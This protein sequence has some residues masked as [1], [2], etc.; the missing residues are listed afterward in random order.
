MEKFILDKEINVFCIRAKSFPNG[1]L[2]AHQQLHALLDSTEDRNFFGISYPGRQGDI[3]YKAAVEESFEGEGKKL[4]CEAFTIKKGEYVSETLMD[5]RKDETV[6]ARTF[7]KLLAAPAIDK[8]TGY[9]LEVY[10][11]ENDM[12]CMIKLDPS[13]I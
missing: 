13:M 4:G 11:N 2:S 3:I 10:L 6:V 5:W 12:R 8:K 7:Q 9:C 1:I